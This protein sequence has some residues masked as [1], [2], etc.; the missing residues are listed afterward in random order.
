MQMKNQQ[1]KQNKDNEQMPRAQA[2][3]TVYASTK[4]QTT[5]ELAKAFCRLT[6]IPFPQL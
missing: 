3:L 5:G 6:F 1:N 4:A 2:I